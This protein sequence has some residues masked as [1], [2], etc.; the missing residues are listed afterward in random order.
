M[1]L[2]MKKNANLPGMHDYGVEKTA[3]EM[4]VKFRRAYR[5]KKSPKTVVHSVK[6]MNLD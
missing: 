5:S 6:T 3:L 2:L 1:S 4:K